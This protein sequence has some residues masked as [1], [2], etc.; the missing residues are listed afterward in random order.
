[1]NKNIKAIDFDMWNGI[2]GFLAATSGGAV[3]RASALKSV[4]PWLA[5]AVSMTSNAVAGMPFE[6]VNSSGDVIDTS[7]DWSNIIGG[8]DSPRRL[9]MLLSSSLCGG[10][11]Y[12]IP[13][14]TSRRLVNLQYV[15]PHTITP[16]IDVNGLQYFDRVT[17]KGRVQRIMPDE[18]IYFWLPDSDVEIGCPLT[19]PMSDALIASELLASMSTTRKT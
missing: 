17:D 4:V 1:M 9:L 15:S 13:V 2:D 14:R 7:S 8:I 12:M 16:Y 6:I 19:S 11:A 10:S 18:L 5:K 3:T